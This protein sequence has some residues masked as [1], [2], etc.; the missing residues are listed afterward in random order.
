MD[1]ESLPALAALR[2]VRHGFSTRS[3]PG[4]PAPELA[5][6]L[7]GVGYRVDQVVTAEQIHRNGVALAE[8]PRAATPGV[9][10]LITCQPGLPL[11]VR[12]ADCAAVYVVDQ[13]TPAIGLVHSGRTGTKLNV[14]GATVAAMTRCF[15]T[16]PTDCRAVISPCIGPC[17]YEVDL[18]TALELQ[19]RD[20]GL[21]EVDNPRICTAC[22]LDRYYS[23]RAEKGHTGR[24]YALL[25][26]VPG[27]P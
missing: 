16:R 7:T 8:A 11:V 20:A 21:R 3:A 25:V 1:V 5:T 15:G 14:V 22:H 13:A 23:Y 18:W 26:L 17:H 2:F 12:C 27:S 19:L 9:D 10:A 6:V 24:M 4:D